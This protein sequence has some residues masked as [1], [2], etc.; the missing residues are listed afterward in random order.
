MDQIVGN[1]PKDF[2]E[3]KI[4]S[5]PEVAEVKEL[6][7]FFDKVLLGDT[8]FLFHGIDT[9][10]I[11][12]TKGWKTRSIT[13]SD[14]E[15]S[16]RGIRENFIES[17]NDNLSLI[18]RRIRVP[19]LW[20]E[21]FQIG[22][23]TRTPVALTYIKGLAGEGLLKEIRTRLE[24]IDTDSIIESGDIE[25]FIEDTPFTFVPLMLRTERVDRVA[26]ALL[27]GQ[28]A[29]I[30]DGTPFVIIAPTTFFNMLQASDDHWEKKPIGSFLRLLRFGAILLSTFLPSL[31]VAVINFHH[32][33][34]PTD[35]FV[36]IASAREEVPF[37]IVIELLLLELVFEVLREA[38]I[39]LPASIGPA[40][41]IVGA[42]VLGDA[43]IRA[44][45]VS[46]PVVII[47]ALTAIASFAVPNFALGIAG[48]L[49]RFLFIALGSI[50][51]FFGIQFGLF[52]LIIHLCSLRSFG[53]PYLAPAAPLIWQNM[54][55]H[56][57]V[58]WKWGLTTRPRLTG[59]REPVRQNPRQARRYFD[60]LLG[61]GDKSDNEG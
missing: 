13:E 34:I 43:A 20:V 36:S 17:I 58:I 9:A 10:L 4:I 11:V 46:P 28:V 6:D 40:I 26:T 54:K 31:Y 52:L 8:A 24:K 15:V 47:V 32:E 45:L 60:T 44:G 35:L 49:L 23:L 55:D 22:S 41:S 38:G 37:P 48:R 59:F 5:S 29:I 21:E 30:T 56:L 61:K 2:I 16:I 3:E 18:R 1:V 19:Q 51:G 53:I 7:I 12:E 57:I 50:F 33:L 14:A 27:E 42:L 25:D 39:R